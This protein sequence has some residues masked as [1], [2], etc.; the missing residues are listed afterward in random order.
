MEHRTVIVMRT[1]CRPSPGRQ[2]VVLDKGRYARSERTKSSSIG[3]EFISGSTSFSSRM[4]ERWWIY[5]PAQHE[6]FA[7]VRKNIGQARL[8]RP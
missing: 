7:R 6:G 5:E 8:S 4:P 3:A 1:A 2:I